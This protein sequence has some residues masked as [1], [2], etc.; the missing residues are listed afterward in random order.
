[1]ELQ[2]FTDCVAMPCCILSVTQTP[3]GG[4]G[5]IRIVCAN[6]LYKEAMGPKYYD[7]MPY[8]ELVPQD[9]KFEDFCYRAAILGQR[10]H[11]YV[12]TKALGSWT[13]QTL[14]PMARG[15]DGIG[16]CQF[17][18]E[19]TEHAEADRM[20]DVSADTSAA[21][22]KA[23]ITLMGT[24]D[25]H[26]NVSSVLDDILK[27]SGADACR[28]MLADHIKQEAVIYCERC[29]PGVWETRPEQDVISYDLTLTWEKLIGV[30]NALII[31]SEQDLIELE[32]KA[33]GWVAMMREY[34]VD[35]LVLIPLRRNGNVIGYL[36]VV[37]FDVER[38]VKV[39][40]LL[41][42]VSYCL[43]SEICNQQLLKRLDDMSRTDALTGLNNRYAMI[44]RIHQIEADGLRK[45]GIVNLDLNGLKKINDEQGHSAGDQKLV[46][47]AELLRKVF[48][49]K[50]IYRTGGD[51]F[52]I[53][54]SNIDWNTFQRK[55]QR[56]HQAL[57]KNTDVSFAVGECWTDDASRLQTA[58]YCAD[59][60][61]Y[62]DKEL[63]YRNNP[64]LQRR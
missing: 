9:N 63:C 12:E 52:I 13:D 41:G 44:A 23:C 15:E 26:Q 4:C 42:L 64:K 29:V 57:D 50:D 40:E 53:I 27:I 39:K 54:I 55:V 34:G 6:A 45:I 48:Y 37:N 22:I 5:E 59:E 31:Q 8:Y 35:S 58:L 11:A 61:M 60:R 47:A 10:M 46:Q 56:L 14:V 16:Y 1:M 7:N 43:T 30:S 38:V 21:V 28:I 32:K 17:I 20:A 18:F 49:E 3:E 25:F 2:A 36:Y 51:E 62:A 19:F 24:D 33:P